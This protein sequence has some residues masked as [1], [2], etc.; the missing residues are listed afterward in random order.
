[1]KAKKQKK[2]DVLDSD[3]NF[4]CSINHLIIELEE[5]KEIYGGKYSRL[6]FDRD[7]N[8]ASYWRLMGEREETDEETKIRQD[9]RNKWQEN[10]DKHEAAL[11]ENLKAK[12]EQKGA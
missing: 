6:Y 11:Y 9:R 10:L 12:F 8:F 2:V 7:R 1:M 3:F 5:I 4:E